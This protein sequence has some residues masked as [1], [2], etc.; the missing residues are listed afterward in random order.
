MDI[1]SQDLVGLESSG[2]IDN[3]VFLILKNKKAFFCFKKKLNFGFFEALKLSAHSGLYLLGRPIRIR[4]CILERLIQNFCFQFY[5]QLYSQ[6]HLNFNYCFLFLVPNFLET[7]VNCV[8][9]CVTQKF[10]PLRSEFYKLF[11]LI[12]FLGQF[13]QLFHISEPTLSKQFFSK[14]KFSMLSN[15]I[16]KLRHKLKKG[17]KI[18]VQTYQNILK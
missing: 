17:Q 6:F 3:R 1:F 12:S 11:F 18:L 2:C 8:A 14:L 5:S 9:N 16:C 15:N 7:C 4:P 10:T 13:R